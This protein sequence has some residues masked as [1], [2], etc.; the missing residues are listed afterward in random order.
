MNEIQRRRFARK[1]K[2]LQTIGTIDPFCRLCGKC[3]WWV[4]FEHH[5]IAGRGYA[6]DLI[7]LC[8]DCHDE[9][10]D[11]QKDHPAM[12]DN[13]DAETIKHMK[14]L[15]GL[16]DLFQIAEANLNAAVQHMDGWPYQPRDRDGEEDR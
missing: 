11:L 15:L 5:H 14:M 2:R 4:R 7:L 1:Y 8:G 3:K 10:S 9:A 6:P 16:K 12:N 13:M